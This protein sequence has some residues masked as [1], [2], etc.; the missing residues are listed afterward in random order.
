MPV[1]LLNVVS[2]SSPAVSP[3][4]SSVYSP[5]STGTA[6]TAAPQKAV[7]QLPPTAAPAAA[8]SAAPVAALT[9]LKAFTAS[10][11]SRMLLSFPATAPSF[12]SSQI[13]KMVLKAVFTLSALSTIHCRLSASFTRI[14]PIALVSG[15]SL[16]C[17]SPPT[18]RRIPMH[19]RMI[20]PS[21]VK[22]SS[23]FVR[24]L[25]RAA[26]FPASSVAFR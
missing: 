10:I 3:G 2:Q 18:S 16:P 8:A 9:P 13:P 7:A 12:A 11:C 22:N 6:F 21:F 5:A 24:I 20:S 25:S 1:C 15:S 14:S 17:R 4:F 26:C 19:S 23:T